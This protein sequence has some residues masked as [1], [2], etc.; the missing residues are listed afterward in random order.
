MMHS[1][2]EFKVISETNSSYIGYCEC[3][4]QYNFA[5]N[6]LL[7]VFSEDELINFLDWLQCNRSSTANELALPNGRTR[8][9]S[10]P[11]GNLFLVFNDTE[12]DEI[13][14]MAAEVK[15]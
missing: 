9:Y 2:S 4:L 11:H 8:V 3:C 15:L 10:S 14:L 5:F 6:N 7:I 1:P 13:D 12:L